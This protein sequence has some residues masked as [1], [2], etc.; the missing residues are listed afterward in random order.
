ML[1]LQ[2]PLLLG[3]FYPIISSPLLV[4]L[5]YILGDLVIGYMLREITALKDRDNAQEKKIK[6]YGNK[7]EEPGM[8]GLTVATLYLFN[9]FTIASC[10]GKSTLLF[11]NMATVAGIWMG[12]KGSIYI[13]RGVFK[14]YFP[15]RRD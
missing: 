1:H 2:A 11:S 12:M 10:I 14:S 15:L 7:M 8:D 5:L 9:P 6:Q 13:S 4:K 3:L